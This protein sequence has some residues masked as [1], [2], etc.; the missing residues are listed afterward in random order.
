[1]TILKKLEQTINESREK[2]LAPL[3]LIRPSPE[4][5]KQVIRAYLKSQA[6]L[7]QLMLEST[8][9]L[10]RFEADQLPSV[11]A[12]GCEMIE[13]LVTLLNERSRLKYSEFEPEKLDEKL[14][15]VNRRILD[16]LQKKG[17]TGIGNG[18]SP[19]TQLNDEA[20]KRLLTD[21]GV[22]DALTPL[23]SDIMEVNA[24]QDIDS[25]AEFKLTLDTHE[26]NQAR[27]LRSMDQINKY[28]KSSSQ[29]RLLNP[30]IDY[31]WSK[32]IVSQ[33]VKSEKKKIGSLIDR[34]FGPASGTNLVNSISS[35]HM[36]ESDTLPSLNYLPIPSRDLDK[37]ARFCKEQEEAL[38]TTGK[39]AA[40]S[41]IEYLDSEAGSPS[42]KDE[43]QP[44]QGKQAEFG[45]RLALPI[46]LHFLANKNKRMF[47][48]KCREDLALAVRDLKRALKEEKLKNLTL[49]Q[50][51]TNSKSSPSLQWLNPLSRRGGSGSRQFVK[52]SDR[53]DTDI[54][55]NLA[56]RNSHHR[57]VDDR[58]RSQGSEP[59]FTYEISSKADCWSKSSDKFLDGKQSELKTKSKAKQ[60][61]PTVKYSIKD[62]CE[63][64]GDSQPEIWH[65]TEKK[66]PSIPI[67]N[68]FSKRIDKDYGTYSSAKKTAIH[69][70]NLAESLSMA[71]CKNKTASKQLEVSIR[72]SNISPLL[73]SRNY[74]IH[75]NLDKL[76]SHAS[77]SRV[78]LKSKSVTIKNVERLN[79]FGAFVQK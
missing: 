11:I 72:D 23:F 25:V 7:Y 57:S 75:E 44:K 71:K 16:M 59:D 77:H 41:T 37:L 39:F 24:K 62:F 18:R 79:K 48:K 38:Q 17:S 63:F 12:A 73:P 33:N 70:K 42:M 27:K 15:K 10:N 46:F 53:M 65:A 74:T 35:P 43:V 1:M 78:S 69:F 13:N 29:E 19:R 61:K 40:K 2:V 60:S 9:S 76:V 22:H 3:L 50:A 45:L 67:L 5:S 47:F 55:L 31:I 6:D 58:N 30:A 51:L 54:P 26:I 64:T 68:I 32:K 20:F 66:A 56:S 8:R 14:N 49:V 4:L 21:D 36:K 52:D 28:G 34:G